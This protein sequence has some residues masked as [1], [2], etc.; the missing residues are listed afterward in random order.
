MTEFG[1]F[2]RI[3]NWIFQ[4]EFLKLAERYCNT[5]QIVFLLDYESI[6]RFDMTTHIIQRTV[7]Q[8]DSLERL[9]EKTHL[10]RTL[11]KWEEGTPF[12]EVYSQVA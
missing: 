10:L 9:Q 3:H 1:T 4:D 7:F 12:A 8:A 6:F 2:L 11:S 5:F